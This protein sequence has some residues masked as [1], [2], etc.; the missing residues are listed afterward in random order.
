MSQLL[1]CETW[2]NP[3]DGASGRVKLTFKR[4]KLSRGATIRNA[5]ELFEYTAE[6]M[7]KKVNSNDTRCNHFETKI[8]FK[9]K[10]RRKTLCD[11]EHIEDTKKI[12]SVRS[13]GVPNWVQIRFTTC[14]CLTCMCNS[15]PCQYPQYADE[16]KWRCMT[17]MK[18]D[19]E[20]LVMTHGKHDVSERKLKELMVISKE[21][22]TEFEYRKE[23]VYTRFIKKEGINMKKTDYIGTKNGTGTHAVNLHKKVKEEAET[24]EK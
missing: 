18:G 9:G 10:I 16:W 12:H 13:T 19:S 5:R 6:A 1:S 20:N 11:S 21:H 7:N 23:K 17:D 4:G 3:A 2:K 22:L 14:C 8:L 24:N 15:G